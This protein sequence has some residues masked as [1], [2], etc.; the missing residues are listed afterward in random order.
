MTLVFLFWNQVFSVRE[1]INTKILK[2]TLCNPKFEIISINSVY[3]VFKNPFFNELYP[4]KRP[5][6]KKNN[7]V[8]NPRAQVVWSF[9]VTDQ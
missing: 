9:N 6:R 7:P 8:S 4:L 2:L 5:I 1:N 3:F